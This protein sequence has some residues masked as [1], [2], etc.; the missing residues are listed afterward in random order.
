MI[1]SG[2]SEGDMNTKGKLHRWVI[3]IA[4]VFLIPA[5]ACNFPVP[6]KRSISPIGDLQTTLTALAT[7]T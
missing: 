3:L 1:L 7:S 2:F 6:T 4:L 5:L